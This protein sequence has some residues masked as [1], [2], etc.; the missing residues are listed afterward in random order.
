M[1]DGLRFPPS[2][3]FPLSFDPMNTPRRLMFLLLALPMLA[4]WLSAA[5]LDWPA[6]THETRPWTRWWWLGNITTE[7]GLRSEMEKYRA[8]G[9]G[10]LEITPI[11][12]VRGQ[13]DRHIDYL[14]P[15]WV[16]RLE[17]VLK[18]AR[19]LDLGVDMATGT[20]WPFGGLWVGEED[21]ARYAAYKS[22]KVTAGRSLQE[23][24]QFIQEPVIRYAGA[25]RPTIE[26][27]RR[28]V[29]E[30]ENLQ[31]F[32]LDQV[33]FPGPLPLQLLMAHPDTGG[34]PVELTSRV[35][36]DGRLDWTAP[37]GS[38]DWTLHGVFLGWHG[39]MVER[40][41]PGG[42]GNVIDHFSADSLHRYL[43]KF[44]EAFAGR[45][46]GGLRGFYN[47][48]YEVD[49]AD[50]ESNWT[51]EFLEEFQRRRGY[52]L[53]MQLPALF[54][55]ESGDTRARV[56]SDHRETI[57]DLLLEEFTRP[58]QRW[59]ATR[60][61]I[62][63]NQAHGSPANILDL[64]AASDIPEQEG[65]DLMAIKMASSAA[66]VT[67]KR[68]A[69][70]EAATW[71]NE[72]FIGTLAETRR[73]VDLF[74]LGGINH[75]CYH[76]TA[77]SPPGE[78][79][80]GFHFYASV[81]LNPSNPSWDHFHGLND[82]VTRAQS[83]LQSGL[84]DE[85]VLLY[86]NIH[87]R[88]AVTGNGAMPHFHGR[89]Q[90]GVSAH[91]AGQLLMAAGHGFDYVS[92]RLLDGVIFADG[93][94]RTGG[95]T[96]RAVVVSNTTLIPVETM[97]KLFA[98]AEAGATVLIHGEP[99][100]DVPGFGRLNQRRSQLQV[101]REALD[102]IPDSSR[103]DGISTLDWGRGFILVGDDLPA[104]MAR[105][106][107]ARE[108]MVDE[109]LAYVRRRDGDGRH[110]FISNRGETSVD[111]W[112]PLATHGVSAVIF[113]LIN[114]TAGIGATR[115]KAGVHEVYLQLAPGESTVVRTVPAVP[116][117][118]AFAYR[119][120]HGEARPLTGVWSVNFIK[121]GP[122]LP[123]VQQI[124][125]L[126]SWTEFGGEA[127]RNF[128][129]TARYALVFDRPANEADG[130]VLDL[131]RVAESARVTLNGRELGTLFDA[132]YRIN[133]PADS[134]QARNT[135]EIEVANLM[136]NRIADLDRRG[137]PWKNFHNI[138]M[139][140]RRGN[141]RGPDGNFSAARWEP[142][143]SGLIGPVTLT[144]FDLFQP[145]P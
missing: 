47:D 60:G 140:A 7:E 63:R 115:L 71:L 111:G 143:E 54:S 76:G 36:P 1:Q 128:S 40:A 114:G 48:S 32:A 106:N 55:T 67:G 9:L 74:L 69:S 87:D 134:L 120:V 41:G 97:R 25:A 5:A 85:D 93:A 137:V 101:F 14:S 123:A 38:G 117:G 56:L 142:L 124:T 15:L 62:I 86:Y 122:E 118:P 102:K 13:E 125:A 51:P 45:D 24:V 91:R 96:Y 139:P 31:E 98:L 10:G 6:V 112:V 11:Y 21:A 80:P 8:A 35:G 29:S 72:H 64:Y 34:A 23:P 138:N 3:L 46:V 136:A 107:V 94:L 92:D 132:P 17:F 12:G 119:R 144:P 81:E 100:S 59:A 105:A 95:T 127:V 99:P 39:K 53:R 104:L 27:I 133:L 130:W 78:P 33:R 52:D 42:E 116:A 129:G 135:L 141:N 131:G 126:R 61:A 103:R 109:G 68:L 110:Y 65:S 75:N 79:W 50:G 19:R 70:S 89:A 121:G 73:T 58:W 30:N 28:P 44:E 49:D 26:Q 22:F 66:H 82:Y 43:A 84:P 57:S 88:W 90:E 113:D 83:F 145:A 18:E 16:N 108:P 2:P 77:Y 20:G 37:A 4:G